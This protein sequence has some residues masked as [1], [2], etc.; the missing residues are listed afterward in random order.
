MALPGCLP[1][2]DRSKYC[3]RKETPGP[4]VRRHLDS[5]TAP[6]PIDGEGGAEVTRGPVPGPEPGALS[7]QSATKE[8]PWRL[9]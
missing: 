9:S 4:V 8:E 5:L 2:A 6:G 3:H 1:T 7:A